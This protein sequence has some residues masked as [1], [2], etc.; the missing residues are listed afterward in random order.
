VSAP[1]TDPRIERTRRVVLDA[2]V[3]VIA[4]SGFRG[5][6]I[7]AIATRSGVA[8]STIY[9]NWRGRTELL[10]EAV[11]ARFGPLRDTTVGEVRR[12]LLSL[13][14][15]LADL[16]THEP[17]ASVAASL[18]LESRR[19]PTLAELHR[20]F[21]E[22]RMQEISET[23]EEAQARGELSLATDGVTIATDL[24]GPIFLRALVLRAPI[25]TAWLE[26]HVDAVLAHYREA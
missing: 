1:A 26:R 7:D 13:A 24:G 2:T 17:M 22:G 10:L 9:R 16:L 3:E 15:R 14:S 20:R 18:I 5:A 4:E 11:R 21:A 25:D 19:D 12:D 8:R 23:V 6:T